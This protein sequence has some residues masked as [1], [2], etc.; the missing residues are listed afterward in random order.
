ML[1]WH[2]CYGLCCFF[3]RARACSSS[4]CYC[5]FNLCHRFVFPQ[6]SVF[7][8]R[9]HTEKMLADAR[10][11]LDPFSFD[12]LINR[13]AVIMLR[14]APSLV[15]EF[16]I[17]QVLFGLVLRS[18]SCPRDILARSS[19]WTTATTVS[20][21]F[22]LKFELTWITTVWTGKQIPTNADS[23]GTMSICSGDHTNP[24]MSTKISHEGFFALFWVPFR[25][26][27]FLRHIT[28]G[29][30]FLIRFQLYFPFF[31]LYFSVNCWDCL[32]QKMCQ[33]QPWECMW[34]TSSRGVVKTSQCDYNRR[35]IHPLTQEC[36][37]LVAFLIVLYILIVHVRV[38]YD[39]Y[40][41]KSVNESLL[42]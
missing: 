24:I 38:C 4:I 42:C 14:R 37:I 8:T 16:N 40:S 41:N 10:C 18:G 11:V 15:S 20:E 17:K 7:Y 32:L 34:T 33:S 36:E 21:L 22:W 27:F 26:F 23:Q 9:H 31:S 5:C 6:L 30:F 39:C 19:L 1:M 29:T 35:F 28:H 2:F 12:R 3:C 13:G 25:M